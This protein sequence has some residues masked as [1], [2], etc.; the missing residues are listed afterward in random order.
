[1]AGNIAKLIRIVIDFTSSN[2]AYLDSNDVHNSTHPIRQINYVDESIMALKT[3]DYD[4]REPLTILLGSDITN[5]WANLTF[6]IGD[7][8]NIPLGIIEGAMAAITSNKAN[9][10]C[11]GNSTAAR[12]NID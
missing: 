6:K 1:M 4:M 2:A 12:G 11:S 10:Y 8:F 7:V 5:S 3:I 9:L